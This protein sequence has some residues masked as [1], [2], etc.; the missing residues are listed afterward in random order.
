M[1]VQ[2]LQALIVRSLPDMPRR[3]ALAARYIV[4]H[5]D[6]VL[7]HSMRDLA[8]RASVAPATLKRL[9][10]TLQ[11]GSWADF[12]AVYA[13]QLRSAPDAYAERA[14]RALHSSGFSALLQ[15]SFA[16]QRINLDNAAGV[17][18][19]EA[20]SRSAKLLGEADR[21][22]IASFMS[23][24]GPGLT[25]AYLCR[26]LRDNVFL[27]GDGTSPLA[28]DL[29]LLQPTDAIL[30]INFQ[31][32]AREADIIV[33]AVDESGAK[34]VCV[35]DSRAT[36]LTRV[37]QET[38]IF[39]VEGPSFFPSLTAA[40]ALV[41]T[42]AIAMLTHLGDRATQRIRHIEDAYYASGTYSQTN[43]LRKVD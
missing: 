26:M 18:L 36:H 42:L 37:A 11:F 24:R 30:T 3:L 22:F 38:L 16:A 19:P 9:V 5:P 10:Q 1:T 31:P 32:Y 21:V 7:V 8:S 35:S 2:E 23:C 27:L 12:R 13:R 6:E 29:A 15:E 17:N 25:F 33:R 39:P 43:I 40:H 20:F 14:R 4:D 34:L 28:A 41:E